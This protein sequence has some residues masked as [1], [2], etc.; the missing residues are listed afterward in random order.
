M[1]KRPKHMTMRASRKSESGWEFFCRNHDR[2]E[3]LTPE[4]IQAMNGG[5]EE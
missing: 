1:P 2:W 5:E 4:H 3:E